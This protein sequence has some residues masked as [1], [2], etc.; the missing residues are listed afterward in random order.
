[1]L[2]PL[3]FAL[4]LSP[5][6]SAADTFSRVE[7]ARLPAIS[8]TN[9]RS[10]GSIFVYS[11]DG[12]T[13]VAVASNRIVSAWD[14]LT[15]AQK[16]RFEYSEPSSKPEEFDLR[17][18]AVSPDGAYAVLAYQEYRGKTETELEGKY[19]LLLADL[20]KEKIVRTLYSTGYGPMSRGGIINFVPHAHSVSFGKDGKTLT[21]TLASFPPPTYG[22][23]AENI[24]LDLEGRRISLDRIAASAADGRPVDSK[25]DESSCETV[26]S[27]GKRVSF[28]QD[29]TTLFSL[30]FSAD[31]SRVFGIF[32]D[33]SAARLWDSA[34]GKLLYKHNFRTGSESSRF[35]DALWAEDALHVLVFN[36]LTDDK[37]RFEVWTTGDER[38]HSEEYSVTSYVG[39]GSNYYGIGGTMLPGNILTHEF[40]PIA[41]DTAHVQLVVEKLDF[42]GSPALAAAPAPAPVLDV[43]SPPVTGAKIDADAFA[44]VIGVEKYRQPGIPPV[45]F[46]ASDAQAMYGY[47]TGAMG[48]DARNV[49]LLTNDQA[50]KTDLEKNLG[51]WLKNRVGPKSRVF[52]YYAGHGSPNPETGQGYLMPYEADPA[53]LEDTA[54]PLAKLYASLGKLPTKDV[55][56]VLDACFSGQGG[57]SLIAKGT[58]PLVSVV[59]SRA[60]P[61]TV[62]LAAAGSNQ[63]SA[64][65]PE[66]RHGLLTYYLLAGLK[67]EADRRHDGS[68]TAEDLIA[69]V[70]PSVERAAKLQNVEQTPSLMS[71]P[72]Y[73]Q[74]PWIVLPPKK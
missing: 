54:Y 41:G 23:H 43:D 40:R 70:R 38:V 1:M 22:G 39:P 55:T 71:P 21:A 37:V 52:V 36:A 51:S 12:K 7:I 9:N 44:V 34:T 58:R 61:N 68:I 45:D 8:N 49:V 5:I 33:G 4:M 16:V 11:P 57:R 35:I 66:A 62:V 47:L 24:A 50:T 32:N 30:S 53:Y 64:S 17:A 15:G 59:E 19:K 20:R 6:A 65:F 18:L 28:L 29:C 56:V 2:I 14:T 74:R 72:E 67:G 63:V 60:E 3:A 42:G 10:M 25:S 69:Y 27:S 73:A 26:D 13:A 31:Q 46:A 48:F